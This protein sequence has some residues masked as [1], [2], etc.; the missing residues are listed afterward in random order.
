[1]LSEK[2][3]ERK[4][5]YN[6]NNKQKNQTIKGSGND[7]EK[8]NKSFYDEIERTDMRLKL[9]KNNLQNQKLNLVKEMVY[10][11]KS[12]PICWKKKINFSKQIMNMFIKDEQFLCYLGRGGSTE[13]I[14]DISNN[15]NKELKKNLSHKNY[16]LNKELSINKY[17]NDNLNKSIDEE[18]SEMSIGNNHYKKKI[19]KKKKNSILEKLLCEEKLNQTSKKISNPFFDINKMKPEKRRKLYRQGIFINLIPQNISL[20]T[21]S[22][23]N[24]NI[25][26]SLNDDKLNSNISEKI[27]SNILAST[28]SFY[29]KIDIKDPIKNKYLKLLKFYGPYYAYCPP[30]NNR[31]MEFYNQLERTQCFNLL[32]YMKK[33][34]NKKKSIENHINFSSF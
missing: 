16:F 8:I 22:K 30:C 13:R 24:I 32:N 33:E 31:N 29:K 34:K 25:K 17:S 26:Q 10:T 20:T 15:N 3:L 7:F 23:S 19:F 11:N 6:I 2:E 1:M 21:R 27:D 28:K 18:S 4:Y 5:A 12:I 9:N 14:N